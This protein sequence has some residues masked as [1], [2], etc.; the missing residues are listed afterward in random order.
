LLN[1]II[2]IS[3]SQRRGAPLSAA[4]LFIL[5]V[6]IGAPAAATPPPGSP[7]AHAKVEELSA[8][9]AG[10]GYQTAGETAFREAERLKNGTAED[11]RKSIEKYQEALDL[12]RRAGDRRAEAITLNNIGLVYDT[13]GEARKALE[14]YNEALPISR[15]IGDRRAE[16]VALNSIGEAYRSLGEMRKALEKYNEALPITRA[17]GDRRAEAITLNNIG[18]VYDTVGEKVLSLV[19]L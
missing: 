15:A 1:Q 4:P 7:P 2:P 19:I 5:L 18:M 12:F 16:A 6:W 3:T 10:E 14:K 11:K 17:I 13:L 8:A 9:T